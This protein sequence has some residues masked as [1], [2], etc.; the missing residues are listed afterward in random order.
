VVNVGLWEQPSDLARELDE[1]ENPLQTRDRGM[2]EAERTL[3][4]ARMECDTAHDRARV[5]KHDN[6]A[7]LC[8]STANRWSSLEFDWVL[9]GGQ[10]VPSVQETDH[11]CWKEELADDQA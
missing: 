11:E 3:G 10:F 9:G 1:R 5:I 2:V 8:A 6:R 7:W 4:R